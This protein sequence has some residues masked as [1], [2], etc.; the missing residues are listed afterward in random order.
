MLLAAKATLFEKA[1]ELGL[2]N[3]MLASGPLFEEDDVSLKLGTVILS[4]ELEATFQ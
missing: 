1:Y 4:S 2:T 3:A